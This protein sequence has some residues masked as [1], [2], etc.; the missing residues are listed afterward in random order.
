MVATECSYLG[1]VRAVFMM[2]QSRSRGMFQLKIIS[3]RR[4]HNLVQTY[5]CIMTHF[6]T[7]NNNIMTH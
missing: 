6:T 1:S 4:V 3:Q 5:I 7:Y 2:R